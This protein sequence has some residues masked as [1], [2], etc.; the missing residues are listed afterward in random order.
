MTGKSRRHHF[1][2][3]AYLEG[4]LEPGQDHLYCYGR[5]KREHFLSSPAKIANIRD[6]H[7]FRKPDGSL[8]T[9]LEDLI[10]AEF[11]S[12]GIPIIRKLALGKIKIDYG[13]R[14]SL[15]KL[16]ALQ[17]V[18]VPY[19]REF[20]DHNAK[21]TLLEHLREMDEGARRLGRPVNA[22]EVAIGHLDRLPRVGEW[23]RLHRSAIEAELKL[24]EEDPL[25]SSREALIF[26]A[27]GIATVYAG[28]E[29]TIHYASGASQFTTSDCPVIKMFRDG[30]P[31][32]GGIKEY[33]CEILFP[34]SGAAL[35]HMKHRNWMVDAVRKRSPNG[36]RRIR[37][38]KYLDIKTYQADGA[39]VR[40]FNEQHVD[41]SH[42]WVFTGTNQEWILA[43]MQKTSKGP[44]QK[45]VVADVQIDARSK[46]AQPMHKT[47]FSWGPGK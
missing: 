44:K 29:W 27:K 21:E 1:V 16:I 15:A 22:I 19:E 43:R 18:R 25:R 28:M 3:R 10:G 30:M 46:S 20:I 39:E 41:Q 31:L 40:R 12:R 5:Y 8:D 35:L 34:L 32:A 17:T 14:L 23:V 38:S 36:K 2:T 33:D 13:Q 24:L 9:S 26:L 11:E 42:F 7:S 37:Q 4:F 45:K 6:Y 47:E